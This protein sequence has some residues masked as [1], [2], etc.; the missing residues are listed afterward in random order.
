MPKI[1]PK[2][3]R[4]SLLGAGNVSELVGPKQA[5]GRGFLR[6]SLSLYIIGTCGHN[7][8]GQMHL[9]WQL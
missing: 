7:F 2:S 9:P 4:G 1:V 5:T 8:L 6:R 3:E